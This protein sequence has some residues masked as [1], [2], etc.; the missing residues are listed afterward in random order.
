MKRAIILVMDSF[1]LGATADA[2]KFGDI[3][4]N[5][6]GHIAKACVNGET[7]GSQRKGKLHL[8]HLTRLGL[9][10]AA[11]GSCGQWPAGFES[12]TSSLIGSY[13]YAEE[14]SS[15][16]DTPSG[17]WEMTGLP[18]TFEWGYFPRTTPCFP[19]DLIEAF[20]K[21]AKL[22]GILG[23]CHASGTQI[24]KDLG[25][26]H[27]QTLKPICYTSADSVFQIAAHEEYFGL[28]RLQEI[29]EIAKELTLPLN[30]GRVI[31]RPFVGDSAETYQR[32][33]NRHDYTTTPHGK[34]LLNHVKDQGADVF[35]IGKI[36]DIFANQG[37]TKRLKATGN[38][39]LFDATL[40]AMKV[41]KEGDLIFA[42][43][44]DFDSQFGHRR[45]I[46]GY[47]LALEAFD[48]RLPELL[49]V[50]TDEDL[51]LITA[52]HG[53]DP[54]WPGTDHT[55]EHV[56]VLFYAK[57]KTSNNLG[58]RHSFADMGQTI[59]THLGINAL[60]VGVSCKL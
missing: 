57:N 17:H 13:G 32:T 4:A 12:D 50:M 29:C 11:K 27:L 42:N 35:S 24:I 23:N 19:G 15:G 45:D 59:A 55:R 54:S 58:L 41:A 46:T 22:P 37:V 49:A 18:V 52:D 3:G 25:D 31:S 14:I 30:I 20:I 21:K 60:N 38:M 56:P 39:A 28:Q 8:P 53:C 47:A 10:Q 51:L 44:V 6:F 2:D 40:S 26:E 1:G 33:G 5:T 7:D 48:Q 9:I 43:F 16:K 36:A 34:T